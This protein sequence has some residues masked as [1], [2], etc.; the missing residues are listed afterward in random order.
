[1]T[2]TVHD[3][4]NWKIRRREALTA[5]DGWL[6]IIG[7]YPLQDGVASLG[8]AGDN[9]IVLPAGPA[10]VGRLEQTS[11]DRVAFVPAGGGERLTLALSKTKPPRFTAGDLLLEVTTLNGENALRVRHTASQAPG[12]LAALDYFPFDPSWRIVA[13]WRAF[14]TPRQLT[15][16]TS[17]AIRTEVAATHRATFERD[18][19]HF[20]LLATHGTPQAP[21]FVIRDGTAGTETYPAARFMFGEDVTADTVVLDFNRAINPPCAFTDFAVCPLP[22]PQN[23][24]PIRIEAGEK[25]PSH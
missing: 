9:D 23:I 6:N 18:G 2:D 3:F 25:K 1:M 8:S 24:L 19:R 13:E 12:R 10:H 17:K 11:A 15:I 20:E 7:R 22:P 16:D 14:E 5:P 4:E 21:Q